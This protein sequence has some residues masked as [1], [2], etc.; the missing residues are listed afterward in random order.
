M[1]ALPESVGIH[2]L[3]GDKDSALLRAIITLCSSLKL[4]VVIEGVESREQI[5]FISSMIEVPHI[6]GYYFSPPLREGP[7][8]DWL[9]GRELVKNA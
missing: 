9:I 1:F 3:H 7:F 6:Q 5:D 2:I 4:K 8:A